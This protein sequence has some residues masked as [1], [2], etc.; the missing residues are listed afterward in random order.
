M[1]SPVDPE[2]FAVWLRDNPTSIGDALLML[3]SVLTGR[4]GI[5]EH[6]RFALDELADAVTDPTTTGIVQALFSNGGFRGDVDNYHAEAN[7]FLDQVLERRTGMPITLAAVVVEVGQRVGVPL[8]MVGM[9]GHVIVGTDDPSHFI[10][11]FGG[12]EVNTAWVEK[13]LQSIFGPNAALEPSMLQ[14]MFVVQTVNRVSN[15]L[16]RTWA[17]DR[18]GQMDRLLE[19]RSV[20]PGSPADSGVTI[21]VATQRGRFDIAAKLREANDPDDPEVNAL[22][23]RLN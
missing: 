20:I 14:Q 1:T 17:D 3:S 11:A 22:W 21:E 5:V 6:G 16:M 19:L 2:E 9:P 4:G 23:A 7:S 18:D 12:I 8:S 13:R 10:D 15:N